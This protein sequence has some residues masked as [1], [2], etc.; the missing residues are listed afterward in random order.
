MAA[1]SRRLIYQL[2]AAGEEDNMHDTNDPGRRESSED[3]WFVREG[4]DIG[5][6]AWT[7]LRSRTAEHWLIFAAGVIAGLILS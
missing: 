3:S 5:W 1:A 2:V 6:R 7:Y 4:R